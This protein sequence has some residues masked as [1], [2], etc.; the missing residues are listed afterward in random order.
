MLVHHIVLV[1]DT[2]SAALLYN[3][4]LPL[5]WPIRPRSS[6]GFLSTM[7]ASSRC[8]SHWLNV[9]FIPSNGWDFLDMPYMDERATYLCP[10]NSLTRRSQRLWVVEDAGDKN[11]KWKRTAD[12]AKRALLT[13]REF[14]Y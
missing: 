6:Y 11:R 14:Q 10:I 1:L 4:E 5:S 9:G 2:L 3:F 7:L 13:H 12:K 8:P